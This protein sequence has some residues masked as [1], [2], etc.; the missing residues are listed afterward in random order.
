MGAR[1]CA[2]MWDVPPGESEGDERPPSA[3]SSGPNDYRTCL[4]DARVCAMM[5][6]VPSRESEEDERPPSPGSSCPKA[7]DAIVARVRRIRTVED[8]VHTLHWL[9]SHTSSTDD[10]QA[11]LTDAL[12]AHAPLTS[13][14]VQRISRLHQHHAGRHHDQGSYALTVLWSSI[15]AVTSTDAMPFL[16]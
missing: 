5:W 1:M 6:E 3:G 15:V 10:V 14:E 4:M 7:H 12:A 11:Q 13:E 16:A 9:S 8:A 2:M